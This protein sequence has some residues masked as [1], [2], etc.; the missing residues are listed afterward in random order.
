MDL[1]NIV[2]FILGLIVGWNFLPQPYLV[3][4]IVDQLINAMKKLVK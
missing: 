3:K 2:F 4:E 1:K